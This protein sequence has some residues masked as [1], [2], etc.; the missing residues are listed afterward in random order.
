MESPCSQKSENC[1]G[2]CF[3]QIEVKTVLGNARC[4]RLARSFYRFPHEGRYEAKPQLL[5][6]RRVLILNLKGDLVRREIF[7]RHAPKL[8]WKWR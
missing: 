5:F 2:T 3:Q 7:G 6:P 4:E 8:C 1:V